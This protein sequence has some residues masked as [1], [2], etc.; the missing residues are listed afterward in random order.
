[1]TD[2][3]EAES[4]QLHRQ[5]NIAISILLCTHIMGKGIQISIEFASQELHYELQCL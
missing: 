3:K 4:L 2:L 5:T 1:M